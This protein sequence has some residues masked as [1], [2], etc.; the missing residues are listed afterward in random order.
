MHLQ[1]DDVDEPDLYPMRYD[2]VLKYADECSPS[3]SSFR[4]P[5][6]L[7]PNPVNETATIPSASEIETKIEPKSSKEYVCTK[8][9]NWSVLHDG[10]EVELLNPFHS[11]VSLNSCSTSGWLLPFQ[12]SGHGFNSLPN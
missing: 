3:Y 11:L 2:A 6:Q 9:T 10:K 4:L 5:A 1:L 12:R 7:V 8:P